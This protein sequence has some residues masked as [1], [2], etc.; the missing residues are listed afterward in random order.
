MWLELR[1]SPKEIPEKLHPL[2]LWG[3][4]QHSAVPVA[5]MLW[6]SAGHQAGT[7]VQQT[8]RPSLPVLTWYHMKRLNRL[9]YEGNLL[10]FWLEEN[11]LKVKSR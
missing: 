2:L 10:F 7:R 11:S 9:H 1:N 6:N 3:I 8:A 5:E 4:E